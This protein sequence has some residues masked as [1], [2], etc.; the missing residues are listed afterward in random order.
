MH[1]SVLDWNRSSRM[2]VC[3]THHCCLFVYVVVVV[4]CRYA[5]AIDFPNGLFGRWL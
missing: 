1:K 4:V 5:S 2:C 3:G